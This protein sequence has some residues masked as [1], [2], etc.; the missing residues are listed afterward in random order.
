MGSVAR[1][2]WQCLSCGER[3][4]WLAV[5]GSRA[6]RPSSGMSWLRAAGTSGFCSASASATADR[7]GSPTVFEAAIPS[8]SVSG[9]SSG[10]PPTA[11]ICRCSGKR[12]GTPLP[13]EDG[14]TSSTRGAGVPGASQ[15][16][17]FWK[18]GNSRASCERTNTRRAPRSLPAGRSGRSW[19]APPEPEKH[20]RVRAD[21][22]TGGGRDGS[23]WLRGRGR[24]RR[25]ENGAR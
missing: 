8:G 19:L 3:P 6:S 24:S 22:R 25:S 9:I 20:E 7:F 15:G 10:S 23:T 13:P 14:W 11:A 5:C 18:E 21:I 16:G 1:Y 17:S 12:S 2:W 4:T